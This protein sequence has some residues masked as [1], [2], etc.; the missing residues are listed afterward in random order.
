MNEKRIL[1][2]GATG[3]IGRH[4]FAELESRRYEIHAVSSKPVPQSSGVHWHRADL[5]D[6]SQCAALLERVK[7]THLLHLA[8]YAE[9]GRFWQALENLDWLQ[10][11]LALLRAFIANGGKRIVVAG[12]CAEYDWSLGHCREDSTPL[13]PQALYGVSKHALRLIIEEAARQTGIS[14]AWG[15]VFFLYG[16]GEHPERLVPLIIRSQFDG[17]NVSCSSG[18]QMRDYMHAADVAAALVALLDSPV[19]GAVNIGSGIAVSVRS[20]V[21][22]IIAKMGR[23]EV[24]AFGQRE[25]GQNQAPLVVADITRLANEVKWSPRYSM[26]R[27]L[28]LTIEWWRQQFNVHHAQ[29]GPRPP[30]SQEVRV[31]TS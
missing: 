27:G 28:E 10:A 19:Q 3:F 22:R 4:C 11:S 21:D 29:S 23:P 1:L 8:W 20:L 6:A 31:T 17:K 5:L 16:P 25:S 14:S 30:A 7:P 9:H 13:R 2:T 12:T 26:D 24:V 15:R 18:E